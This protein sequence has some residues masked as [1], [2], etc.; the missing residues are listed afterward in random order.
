MISCLNAHEAMMPLFK[1]GVGLYV[2]LLTGIVLI[3]IGIASAMVGGIL[4]RSR[5]RSGVAEG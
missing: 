1:P 5:H 2:T 3:P 4:L